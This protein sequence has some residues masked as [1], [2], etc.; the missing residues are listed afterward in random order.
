MHLIAH[1]PP[2]LA[3]LWLN[4]DFTVPLGIW[5][6]VGCFVAQAMYREQERMARR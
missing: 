3:W 1:D 4:R 2:A 5:F 6:G